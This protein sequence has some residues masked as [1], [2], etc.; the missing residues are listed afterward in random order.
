MNSKKILILD[1]STDRSETSNIKRWLPLESYV[2]SLFI[3]SEASFPS[4]LIKDDFT[5]VI[6]TGSALSITEPAPFT[7]KAV[8]YIQDCRKKGI[9]QMG[10]CYGHQL[11]CRALL[12]KHVVRASP[13][14]FEAG[15]CLVAFT[16]KAMDLF[17]V[18]EN[19]TVWQHHFDEVT[20]LPE[21]SEILA[22]NPHTKF[23]S[24]INWDQRLLGTQF[25]P[26]F[27]KE[28]GNKV[29]LEDRELLEK[30]KYDVDAIIRKGPSLEWGRVFFDF[31]P[32]WD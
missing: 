29:F 24:F 26:E 3:D 9:S 22:T 6:H 8:K 11:V 12:G 4:D 7:D 32:T 2:S 10:I 19:E 14:G 25:H 5:H 16:R 1:Y 13:Q 23:Q 21:G 17:P 20:Q 28:T 31:F 15:W 30:N 27:D 18:K